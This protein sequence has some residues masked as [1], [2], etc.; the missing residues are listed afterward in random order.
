M[1]R[2]AQH[3]YRASWPDWRTRL[4]HATR[5]DGNPLR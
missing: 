4:R 1:Y 3:L 2:S 5:R